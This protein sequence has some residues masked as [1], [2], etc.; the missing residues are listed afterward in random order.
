MTKK[1]VLMVIS[2]K[3][4][5]TSLNGSQAVI[6]FQPALEMGDNCKLEL[7]GANIWYSMP[8]LGANTIISYEY[9]KELRL[10]DGSLQTTLFQNNEILFEPGL[11]GLSSLNAT[12]SRHLLNHTDLSRYDITLSGDEST[13]RVAVHL[14]TTIRDHAL[15]E[16]EYNI[17]ELVI[18]MP[19]STLLTQY[20]GYASDTLNLGITGV[21]EY[22]Y[23][24]TNPASLNTLKSI[25]VNCR[26]CSGSMLNGKS[27]GILA[28]IPLNVSVGAQIQYQPQ[29]TAKISAPQMSS[30]SL[31]EMVISLHNQDMAPLN[32][33]GEDWEVVLIATSD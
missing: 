12:I 16:G 1:E 2:S 26:Q 19:E 11:Y 27:S 14:K 6:A 21:A 32:M 33:G 7:T 15:T 28:N 5:T 10:A 18:R 29:N 24:G 23:I 25:L 31:N 30:S 9:T 8:N 22:E 4:A 13:G 17:T 3:T 20:L